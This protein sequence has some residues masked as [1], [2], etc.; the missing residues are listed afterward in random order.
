MLSAQTPFQRKR[1]FRSNGRPLFHYLRLLQDSEPKPRSNGA[2]IDSSY[3]PRKIGISSPTNQYLA[4]KLPFSPKPRLYAG[5]VNLARPNRDLE[6]ERKAPL[7]RL[8]EENGKFDNRSQ[9]LLITQAL[10]AL[11]GPKQVPTRADNSLCR[12]PHQTSDIIDR[13]NFDSL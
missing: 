5:L 9:F 3:S 10:L 11:P 12:A 4:S 8:I 6:S 13:P 2:R 7:S 1:R